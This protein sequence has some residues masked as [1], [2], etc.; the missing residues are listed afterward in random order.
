MIE[1]VAE[2]GGPRKSCAP[3]IWLVIPNLPDRLG[4]QVFYVVR[5]SVIYNE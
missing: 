4:E 2:C 5:V 1:R 3:I